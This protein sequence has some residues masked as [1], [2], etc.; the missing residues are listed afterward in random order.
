M[1]TEDLRACDEAVAGIP[2][3]ALL[4]TD[5]ISAKFHDDIMLY[6]RETARAAYDRGHLRASEELEAVEVDAYVVAATHRL[7][8][9]VVM[10]DITTDEG[11]AGMWV[12]G[13]VRMFVHRNEALD[14]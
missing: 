4:D 11:V 2:W 13:R 8:S 3:T 1:N 6:A 7:P 12:E 9:G 10:N 5:I 14:A